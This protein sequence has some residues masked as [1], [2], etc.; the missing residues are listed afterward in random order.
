MSELPMVKIAPTL[1]RRRHALA[2]APEQRTLLNRVPLRATFDAA[3]EDIGQHPLE[4]TRV[5]TL[6]INVG[7]RCNQTCKHCH[8]DAGPDRP[9]VMSPAVVAACLRFLEFPEVE[10]LDITGGAPELHPQ[11][12]EIIVRASAMGKHILDRCNLTVTL[13]PR[14]AHL[15][16]L[17]AKHKVEVIASMPSYLPRQTDR[18]RGDGV[19]ERSLEALQ[20]FNRL[21]YGQPDSGL[22]LNLVTNPVGA[23]LPANQAALEREWQ[24]EFQR[25]YNIRFNCLYTITNMPISRFLEFLITSGNLETYLQRLVGAFNPL[26]VS[27]LMCRNLV[28]VGWDG[29]LYDCDFNQ[30][31]EMPLPERIFGATPASLARRAI[32]TAPHCYGCT[33]GVGSS[34]GGATVPSD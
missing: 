10:T 28:S 23:F 27:G 3:M 25:R 6:Q 11:F 18:Q 9:E 34:C 30:M 20:H 12:E 5:D 13:L 14:Y 21:G 16:A 33:A 31:L 2:S 29:Q 26:T 15:P 17:M 22:I 4:A 32:Q 24:L 7:K 19:F 8:V 1:F